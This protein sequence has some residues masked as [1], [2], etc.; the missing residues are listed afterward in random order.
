[1]KEILKLLL[2]YFS[3]I[4]SSFAMET[5]G[6]L[7]TKKDYEK[8]KVGETYS[9]QLTLVPFEVGLLNMSDLIN[10]RIFEYFYVTDVWSIESSENNSDAVVVSLDMV[11]AKKFE[12][13]NFVIWPLGARNIPVSFQLNPIE[14][15]KLTAQKFTLFPG[16]LDDFSGDKELLIGLSLA[17]LLLGYFITRKLLRNNKDSHKSKE[18]VAYEH[19]LSAT[20]HDDFELVFRN[21][22]DI[23]TKLSVERSVETAFND[24]ISEI[25]RKQYSPMWR[26]HPLDELVTLKERVIEESRHGV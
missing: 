19:F 5:K 6:I 24:L 1:M 2:I 12:Q 23:L 18:T 13:R 14:D 11:V 26:S 16:V 15:T 9:F 3:V 21:R 17:L 22:R 10:K 7:E 4:L 25:E 20:T 8:L